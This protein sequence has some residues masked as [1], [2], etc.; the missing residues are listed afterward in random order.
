MGQ[1]DAMYVFV[2]LFVHLSMLRCDLRVACV[3]RTDRRKRKASLEWNRL[4]Y[5]VILV[6]LCLMR[7][8]FLSCGII[9]EYITLFSA[10]KREMVG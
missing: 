8:A 4:L 9:F 7:L 3:Y 1:A 2:L 10:N 5:G 6:R